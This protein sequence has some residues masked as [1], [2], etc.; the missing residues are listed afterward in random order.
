MRRGTVWSGRVDADRG[1]VVLAVEPVCVVDVA[2]AVPRARAL[3]SRRVKH[4]LD[5][6]LATC[7]RIMRHPAHRYHQRTPR[8]PLTHAILIISTLC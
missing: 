8:F 2:A 6:V 7:A 4:P 5:V 1:T 3:T